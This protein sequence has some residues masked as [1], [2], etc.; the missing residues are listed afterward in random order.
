[1]NVNM[2]Q[3]DAAAHRR[4]TRRSRRREVP[5]TLPGPVA[6]PL[7]RR[8]LLD[9][10]V[11]G[12]V[13]HDLSADAYREVGD[14]GLAGATVYADLD[15]DAAFDAGE[16]SAVIDGN[17]A[18]TLTVAPGTYTLRVTGPQPGYS[19]ST[20]AAGSRTVTLAPNGSH[21]GAD[22][23]VYTTGTVVVTVFHDFD[24]DGVPGGPF[25]HPLEGRTVYDDANNND[26][27]D[28]GEPSRV[29]GAD[30]VA[31]FEKM[32]PG[33]RTLRQVLPPGWADTGNV[34]D[35]AVRKILYSGSTLTAA[36]GTRQPPNTTPLSGIVYD[37]ANADRTRDTGEAG[38]PGQTLYL[39]ADHDGVL[40]PGE[41]TTTTNAAGAYTFNAPAPGRHHVR[42]VVPEGWTRTA[43]RGASREGVWVVI[44][45]VGEPK[46]G[47]DFGMIH[48][49]PASVSGRA[50]NDLDVDGVR[51]A[52]EPALGGG[53]VYL[54]FD[55]D[56]WRDT[57]EPSAPVDAA[58]NYTLGELPAGTYVVGYFPP[59]GHLQ[60]DP[61][62][63]E[64]NANVGRTVTV[65]AGENATLPD[66]GAVSRAS[67]GTLFGQVADDVNGDGRVGSGDKAIVSNR[68]A[69]IDANNNGALDAGERSYRTLNNGFF[70]DGLAPGTHTVRVV[71][72]EGY[73]QTAPWPLGSG[74]T[75]TV[76]AGQTIAPLNFAFAPADTPSAI[77]GALYL[78]NNAN[79]RRD[80]GDYLRT[81]SVYLDLNNDG[82][83]SPDEP[84]TSTGSDGTY[85]FTRLAAGTYTVRPQAYATELVTTPAGG[86]RTVTVGAHDLSPNNDFGFIAIA[87]LPRISGVVFND[88][89]GD[90]RFNG[91]EAA[92]AGRVVWIDADNDFVLDPDERSATQGVDGYVIS[93]LLPG[94]YTVRAVLPEG[95]R[96]TQPTG[97]AGRTVTVAVGQNAI[98]TSFGLAAA[99]PDATAPTVS[100][101]FVRASTW[102]Q[103]MAS[104]LAAQNLGDGGY[105]VPQP[106]AAA[107]RTL[108]WVNLDTI[109]ARF[110]E[111]VK[112]RPESLRV[113]G[114]RAGAIGVRDFR[115]DPATATATW[116]LSR[117]LGGDRIRV[118]L[119]GDGG[120]GITDL[121]GNR[122]SNA[123]GT[124]G[125][126]VRT[127]NALPGDATGDGRVNFQ[128]LLAVRRR[129]GATPALVRTY[130]V[131]CDIDGNGRITAMDLAYVRTNFARTLPQPLAAAAA[132]PLRRTAPLRDLYSTVEIL[133]A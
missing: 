42:H 127:F 114:A 16:P 17:G 83:R 96:Q 20:P 110:S 56:R 103:P 40:D 65:A 78:D 55:N 108:P 72:P 36:V 132:M 54:D 87:K 112:V 69:Y 11:N 6:E 31:R 43:P 32:K 131:F 91:G 95:M 45:E 28:A 99:P 128:D 123:A 73:R 47:F 81:G 113:L 50:Y 10:T 23:G 106:P 85:A 64:R 29:T 97:R 90:G 80:A 67:T 74:Y 121:A 35:P 14:P 88:A 86:A 71:T 62:R 2:D 63:D 61:M 12:T 92:P 27:L 82:V 68:V 8:A 46:S 126:D 115:Y 48:A 104:A 24:G 52:G 1:M 70:L 25:D 98:G 7:E 41:T 5:H 102:S 94:T 21:Y 130:N 77:S 9:A 107:A 26:R 133:P 3:F 22:F 53:V 38:V 101:V 33:A 119:E 117:P 116:R 118:E 15:G 111:D 129:L 122:L 13:F 93:D 57:A 109:V 37:D 66:F 75:V 125:D 19:T 4:R 49:P 39:D 44:A 105:A 79:G 84:T 18:Y 51:D 59:S 89:N 60:T 100:G 120:E 34:Y 124:A 30:G 76:A 58:G